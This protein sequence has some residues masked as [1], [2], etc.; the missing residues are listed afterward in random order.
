MDPAA[1]L[2]RWRAENHFPDTMSDELTVHYIRMQNGVPSTPRPLPTSGY[3]GVPLTPPMPP[4]TPDPHAP[5]TPVMAERYVNE[6]DRA[7]AEV[8]MLRRWRAENHFPDTMSD[9]LT[10]HYL[11]MQ[12][13]VPSTPRPLPASGY[14]GVPPPRTPD[15][16]A[17]ATPVMAERYVNEDDLAEVELLP[18]DADMDGAG[19]D[20]PGGDGP[21]GHHAH[22]RAT[23]ANSN[24]VVEHTPDW[25]AVFYP[26]GKAGQALKG[27]G[28]KGPAPIPELFNLWPDEED[29]AFRDKGKGKVKGKGSKGNGGHGKGPGNCAGKGSQGQRRDGN[30]A[31]ENTWYGRNAA[32]ARHLLGRLRA[33]LVALTFMVS[34]IDEWLLQQ[35]EPA[36]SSSNDSP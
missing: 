21:I 36:S 14:D 28:G 26:K 16:N 10:V 33:T 15:P 3:D 6:D 9:E 34:D 4:R 29:H 12:R 18:R 25:T 8:E 27:N 1:A 13:G 19:A 2:R 31:G 5:A 11:R 32:E 17:P 30:N 20:G 22:R 24:W 35:E 23:V 7:L